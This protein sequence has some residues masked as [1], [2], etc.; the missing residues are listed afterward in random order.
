MSKILKIAITPEPIIVEALFWTEKTR[1]RHVYICS[2]RTFYGKDTNKKVVAKNY[3]FVVLQYA[4]AI[5]IIF[6]RFLFLI[7]LGKEFFKN[8]IFIL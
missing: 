7:V 3:F 2:E 6:F 8:K 1:S 4:V 5:Y